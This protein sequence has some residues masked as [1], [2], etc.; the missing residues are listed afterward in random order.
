MVDQLLTF[1]KAAQRLDVSTEFLKRLRR[2]G[3]L[4]AV[5]LGR[6]VRVS[7]RE[8]D[9]LCREEFRMQGSR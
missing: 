3:R 2:Q 5:R 1:K 6:A 9:R 8:L 7:E 4:R